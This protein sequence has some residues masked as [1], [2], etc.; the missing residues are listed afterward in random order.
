MRALL[1]IL[2][3]MVQFISI[4]RSEVVNSK[5]EGRQTYKGPY[6]IQEPSYPGSGRKGESQ[7]TYFVKDDGSYVYDGNFI[8]AAL[9]PK[10]YVDF[11]FRWKLDFAA[12][13]TYDEARANSRI[14]N[15]HHYDYPT[16]IKIEG[17]FVNGMR[18]GIWLF[19][20]QEY[21]CT[22]E[23]YI[24]QDSIRINYVHGAL[25]GKCDYVYY[26]ISGKLR[27]TA[28]AEYDNNRLCHS[29]I[30]YYT[31]TAS[32]KMVGTYKLEGDKSKPVGIWVQEADAGIIY[33]DFNTNKSEILEKTTGQ[34]MSISAPIH[35][36]LVFKV[37]FQP[38]LFNFNLGETGHINQFTDEEYQKL[39]Q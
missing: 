24:T 6:R 1:F 15:R 29:E 17:K 27:K 22:L 39:T 11:E 31:D 34:R 2:M 26:S 36:P 13:I 32:R 5:P 10:S 25:H 21:N 35:F 20:V 14:Y 7:Y 18:E 38:D 4:C 3:G 8:Y 33:H 23:K 30:V 37:P 12:D 19:T 16:K 9:Y 28:V